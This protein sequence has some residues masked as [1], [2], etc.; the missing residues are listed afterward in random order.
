MQKP[1]SQIPVSNSLGIWAIKREFY[2]QGCRFFIY[3]WIVPRLLVWIITTHSFTSIFV[4]SMVVVWCICY[5]NGMLIFVVFVV[6]GLLVCFL[7][8]F[9]TMRR[10]PYIVLVRTVSACRAYCG[11]SRSIPRSLARHMELSCEGEAR[12]DV[13]IVI[14]ESA[15]AG[16]VTGCALFE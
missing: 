2:H 4:Y 6:I 13:P 15:A 16:L 1:W 7:F 12:Q 3:R 11:H 14:Y 5:L 9:F 8:F 10:Y